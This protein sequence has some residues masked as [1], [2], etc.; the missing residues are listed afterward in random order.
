[1]LVLTQS[2]LHKIITQKPKGFGE[3]PTTYHSDVI[4]LIDIS[5]ADAIKVFDPKEGVDTI[6]PGEQVIY[7]Q[8]LSAR[9]TQSRLNKVIASKL[10]QSMTIRNWNTTTKLLTLLSKGA[11]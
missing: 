11:S 10:Y 7:S 2:Q 1:V 4:F 3:D 8:R 5:V 9:R 6:W